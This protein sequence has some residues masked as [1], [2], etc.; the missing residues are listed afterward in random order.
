MMHLA[1]SPLLPQTL[2]ACQPTNLISFL[3]R[4]NRAVHFSLQVLKQ[5]GEENCNRT[6]KKKTNKQLSIPLMFCMQWHVGH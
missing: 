1:P 3:P 5:P 6:K 2:S 4:V